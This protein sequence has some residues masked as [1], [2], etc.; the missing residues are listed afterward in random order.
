MT[1]EQ[2]FQRT[3]QLVLGLTIAAAGV[4]F[5]LDNLQILRAGDTSDTGRLCFVAIGVAQIAQSRTSAG[6]V[7]GA[8]W[9]SIGGFLLGTR[10]G[11]WRFSIWVYWPVA[12][13]LF[14][15]SIV[16]RAFSA[17]ASAGVPEGGGPVTSAIA[18]LGASIA[19][20]CRRRS[21][22]RSSRRSWAAAS[23]TCATP[24]LPTERW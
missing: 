18:V 20:L 13:I 6:T 17:A 4:L 5:T 21:S 14:G 12:L 9:L 3:T 22:G 2:G 8:I 1:H 15:G 19:R 7:R 16:W 11:L 24:V 10:L 23:W